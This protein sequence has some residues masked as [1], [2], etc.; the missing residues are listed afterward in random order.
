MFNDATNPEAFFHTFIY[1]I[2]P[3]NSGLLNKKNAG[4]LDLS[5]DEAGS[6]LILLF[7]QVC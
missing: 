1:F 5:E 6:A 3:P 4:L 2:L 7:I